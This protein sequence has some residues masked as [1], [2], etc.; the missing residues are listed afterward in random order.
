M[1]FLFLHCIICSE[2]ID[3][4]CFGF[5]VDGLLDGLDFILKE[6]TWLL[7]EVMIVVDNV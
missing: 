4:F 2:D 3:D 5:F 6:V 1:F 7:R